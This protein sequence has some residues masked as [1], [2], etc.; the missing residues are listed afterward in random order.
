MTATRPTPSATSTPTGRPRRPRALAAT[1]AVVLAGAL[2]STAATPASATEFAV[3]TSAPEGRI[4]DGQ[5]FIGVTGRESDLGS[6]IVGLQATYDDQRGMI[7]A[8]ITFRGI[9]TF[10]D[11]ASVTFGRRDTTGGC[12]APAADIFGFTA[13]PD[14]VGRWSRSDVGEASAASGAAQRSLIGNVLTIGATDGELAGRIYDCVSARVS[15]GGGDLDTVGP[16]PLTVVPGTETGPYRQD[17]EIRLNAPTLGSLKRGRWKKIRVRVGNV[18]GRDASDTRLEVRVPKGMDL[19]IGGV[20]GKAARSRKQTRKLGV[21]VS[22]RTK[23]VTVK[24]RPTGRAADSGE[25]RFRMLASGQPTQKEYVQWKLRAR[26]RK[27]TARS[28][29]SKKKRSSSSSRR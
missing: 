6:D 25:V 28:S 11:T 18:G 15:V 3:S 13:G 7:V 26:D 10:P 19:R 24:V 29:Q 16:V 22:G 21:L 27:R 20:K 9:P 8:N 4:V 1:G 23:H 17:A 14:A 2:A 12:R 5:P